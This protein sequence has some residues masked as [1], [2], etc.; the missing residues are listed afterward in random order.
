[1][2]ARMRCWEATVSVERA[3]GGFVA[4][5]DDPRVLPT[6]LHVGDYVVPASAVRDLNREADGER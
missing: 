2:L 5:P 4:T 6:F 3:S 1:M